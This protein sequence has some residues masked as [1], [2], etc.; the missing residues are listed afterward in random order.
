[1]IQTAGPLFIKAIPMVSRQVCKACIYYS[2]L[3]ES[4]PIKK[5]YKAFKDTWRCRLG[6]GLLRS[7][8]DYS[9]T[10]VLCNEENPARG[11]PKLMEHAIAC[12]M[13]NR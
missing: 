6:V 9:Y 1:M 3:R 4:V 12:G 7:A 11:C 10:K 13:S 8:N 2:V 5:G